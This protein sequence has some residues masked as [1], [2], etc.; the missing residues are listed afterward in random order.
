MGYEY[1][2]FDCNTKHKLHL[3]MGLGSVVSRLRVYKFNE[4]F[5]YLSANQDPL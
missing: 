2:G 3:A 5:K 1:E 4:L